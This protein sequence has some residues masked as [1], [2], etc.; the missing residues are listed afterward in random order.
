MRKALLGLA[1]A[2]GFAAPFF[3]TPASADPYRWCAMYGGG[4]GGGASNCGFVSL[5]QCRLTA[6]GM[7]GFCLENQFYSGAGPAV[8][9]K[10]RRHQG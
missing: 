5:E 1:I 8:S 4:M 3:A 9:S 7:G 10:R 6:S 2:A